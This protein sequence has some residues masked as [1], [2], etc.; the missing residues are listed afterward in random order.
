MTKDGDLRRKRK[1]VGHRLLYQLAPCQWGFCPESHANI[2]TDCHVIAGPIS[3]VPAKF[4]CNRSI[5]GRGDVEQTDRQ[6]EGR[7]NPNYSMIYAHS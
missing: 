3:N 1:S 2:K 6:T 7:T 5:N 4:G